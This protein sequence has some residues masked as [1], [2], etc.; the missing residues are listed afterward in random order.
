M[1]IYNALSKQNRNLFFKDINL[2]EK[3]VFE[4]LY[5]IKGK[6]IPYECS[7]ECILSPHDEFH[8]EYFSLCKIEAIKIFDI[9]EEELE[10]SKLY[11]A[12]LKAFNDI[13][14]CIRDAK[15]SVELTWG[16]MQLL[17]ATTTHNSLN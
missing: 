2:M 1:C 11:D 7:A 9:Y 6:I 13:G 8:N 16:G 5:R 17:N 3:M 10:T 15:N 12:D 14:K 4:Y